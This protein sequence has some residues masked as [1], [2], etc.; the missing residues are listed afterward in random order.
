[1]LW[2]PKFWVNARCARAAGHKL[3]GDPR[4]SK[5]S[6]NA[7]LASLRLPTS[8]QNAA[9]LVSHNAHSDTMQQIVLECLPALHNMQQIT[10][11]WVPLRQA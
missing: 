8:P 5:M 2:D 1:M 3:W 10:L 6:D 4:T 9:T 7:P 11:E